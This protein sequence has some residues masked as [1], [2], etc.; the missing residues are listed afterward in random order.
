[1]ERDPKL[2]DET[3]LC[4]AD[5]LLLPDEQ[6][7]ARK[8]SQPWYGPFRIVSCTQPDITVVKVYLPQN[9]QIKVHQT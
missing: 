5:S 1:M 4:A 8:L 3:G 9:G 2:E 7:I 6:G